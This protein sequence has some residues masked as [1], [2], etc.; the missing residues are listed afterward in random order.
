MDTE[1]LV[2]KQIEDGQKFLEALARHGVEV[3]GAFWLARSD[4][5]KWEL[6]I[7][8]PLVD[9]EGLGPAYLAMHPAYREMP[10]PFRLYPY[11]TRLIGPSHPMAKDI[12]AFT[13]RA[14]NPWSFPL[15]W[16]S[17]TVGGVPTEGVYIYPPPTPPAK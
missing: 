8:T 14:G 7:V 12:L 11:L 10:Q 6:Y 9:R 1:T 17:L 5:G 2:D 3:A 15:Q 13:S 16:S 4:E